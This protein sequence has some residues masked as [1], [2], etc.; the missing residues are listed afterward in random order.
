MRTLLVSIALLSLSNAACGYSPILNHDTASPEAPRRTTIHAGDCE[1]EFPQAGLCASFEWGGELTSEDDMT[2]TIK[3]WS[4]ADGSAAGPYRDADG[5][6]AV[7][8]WMPDMNHG[9]R[10]VTVQAQGEGIYSATRISF[11][12]PGKWEVR[13]QIKKNGH[14]HEQASFLVH[15]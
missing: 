7:Q 1:L 4:R 6:V 10:K 11:S 5:E 3:F 9:S 2:A 8:L 12:M 15:L 14:V 13:L